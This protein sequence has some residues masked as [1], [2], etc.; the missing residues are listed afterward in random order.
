MFSLIQKWHKNFGIISALFVIFLAASGLM[1]NHS[2]QLKLNTNYIQTEWLLDLYQINPANE[3]ISFQSDN[4]WASQVGER[5]YFNE[6]EV[7][8][9]IESIVGFLKINDIY[10]L[11][12]D[13]QITLLTQA[14]EIV[15]HLTSA[16]GVPAGMSA[17]GVGDEA[18]LIIK[19]A[20]GYYLVNLDDLQ[21]NEFDHLEALWSQSSSIPEDLKANLLRLYRGKGLTIERVMLDFHSGRIV[22]EWGVYIVDFIAI[23]FL[24]LA[25]SGLWMWW[26]RR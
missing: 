13:G 1:L 5:L 11:A 2:Q 3:P 14:G 4:T 18:N 16:V 22:G 24:I 19:A 6:V 17:I 20:H 10:V 8:K 9:E 15:E 21:W 26:E 25:G 23:L 12:Y 7:G